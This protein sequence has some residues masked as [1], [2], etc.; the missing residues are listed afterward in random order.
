MNYFTSHRKRSIFGA[1]ATVLVLVAGAA[2]YWTA[3]GAGDGEATTGDTIAL[4][5]NQTNDLEA[6]YP[7][8]SAQTLS[9]TFTNT[10]SGPIHVNS[11]TVSIDSVIDSN[12]ATDVGCT[13]SDFTMTGTTMTAVQEVAV[14][15]L[16]AATGSWTGATIK[17]NNTGADQNL[18]KD[19]TVNL[20]YVIA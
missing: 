8:D 2:A 13:A 20:H 14:G 12:G 19:A 7:G 3:G 11:V 5:V 6:M 4:V 17:F 16:G 15:V 1:I 10:N 18:C 9:G